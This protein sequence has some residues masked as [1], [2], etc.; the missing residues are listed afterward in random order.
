MA[1]ASSNVTRILNEP[2]LNSFENFY[3]SNYNTCP[4]YSS[5]V[6]YKS[7]NLYNALYSNTGSNSHLRVYSGGNS[8][9]QWVL[10]E[11]PSAGA[12]QVIGDLN[13]V[14]TAS[15]QWISIGYGDYQN[16][17][18]TTLELNGITSNLKYSLNYQNEEGCQYRF[19]D[20]STTK[21]PFAS[22]VTTPV[23][24]QSD[25]NRCVSLTV[26][27]N[28]L[29]YTD[30]CN[31]SNL[32][33]PSGSN[34]SIS[35]TMPNY[36]FIP[37]SLGWYEGIF[38]VA[39][40]C[41]GQLS[42]QPTPPSCSLS[43]L[44]VAN[45]N[46]FADGIIIDSASYIKNVST[47]RITA[48]TYCNLPISSTTQS[49]IVQ[50]V[51]TYTST[52]TS[53]AIT[54][55]VANQIFTIASNASN[56]ANQKVSS[57]WI[58]S[59]ANLYWNGTG[60]LGIG[61][62]N[63]TQKLEVNGS[64]RVSGYLS[65][66]N[67]GGNWN[68]GGLRFKANDNIT[69][70]AQV[71][72][73]NDG[74]LCFRSPSSNISGSGGYQFYSSSGTNVICRMLDNGNVGIGTSSPSSTLD[75][76]GQ[77][78]VK[79][80]VGW[81]M[82][83][84]RF[85][86]TSNIVDAAIVQGNNGQLYFRSP[87]QD[88]N[89]G[90]SFVASDG[91]T[92]LLRITNAGNVGIG[93][94]TPLNKLHVE[95]SDSTG[96]GMLI[97]N[98]TGSSYLLLI[99]NNNQTNN[100]ELRFCSYNP[101]SAGCPYAAA[102]SVKDGVYSGNP[103]SGDMLFYSKTPGGYTNAERL[104]MIILGNGNIGIGTDNPQFKLHNTGSMFIGDFA[105]AST[106]IPSTSAQRNIANGM[107]L[108]FDNTFNA[109]AGSGMAANKIVLFN[110]NFLA[111]F[112]MEGG[113]VTY[114]SGGDHNFYVATNNTS[115]YGTLAMSI[116]SSGNISVPGSISCGNINSVFY[117]SVA[118]F[119]E[120]VGGSTTLPWGTSSV[121]GNMRSNCAG[122]KQQYLQIQSATNAAEC[123]ILGAMGLNGVFNILLNTD[124]A[125]DNYSTFRKINLGTGKTAFADY[126]ATNANV[127]TPFRVYSTVTA[128]AYNTSSDRRQKE[129]IISISGAEA[130]HAISKLEGY[131]YNMKDNPGQ[132]KIGLIA[133]E[134]EDVFP[135]LVATDEEGYKSVDYN[136]IIPVLL[137]AVKQ[138][139]EE[140]DWLRSKIV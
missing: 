96:N 93:T 140:V 132:Q 102:I 120:E 3:D 119:L 111:G 30:I 67:S 52:S 13:W 50:L 48:V 101:P 44:Y 80:D 2:M 108:V 42:G 73:G 130:L 70:D 129:N 133:Q 35:T 5:N 135:Q 83:G 14:T 78:V 38:S 104:N 71:T 110:N 29:F 7:I 18:S 75:V 68:G 139:K 17:F 53:N 131:H 113:A 86:S 19:V 23:T 66:N 127:Y 125:Y 20:G 92:N 28:V 74:T 4:Y 134:L 82:G 27:S 81:N 45:Y 55:N 76:N 43:N 61:L 97:K 123:A 116:N 89:N 49:G 114:H 128:T 59:G 24:L 31:T 95:M 137:Q 12:F 37:E 26:G 99:S 64:T 72:Q 54:Q 16:R 21:L 91:G 63:P 124:R 11:P 136:G 56:V 109:T 58:T 60:N 115:T 112:G 9:G 94:A 118:F 6:Y 138:I 8:T 22:G 36:Y 98:N 34:F 41:D 51:N 46:Y 107:R 126:S 105:Y 10:F 100:A 77:I 103:Y 65:V 79:G 84:I 40:S 57:Q 106:T 87:A 69:D 121:V 62:T 85:R 25:V 117:P 90:Y 15:N 47:D 88:G 32:T 122:V 33:P 39:G 1:V